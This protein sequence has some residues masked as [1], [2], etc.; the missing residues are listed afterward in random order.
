MA[1][2]TLETLPREFARKF[3]PKKLEIKGFADIEPLL[4]KLQQA[5]VSTKAN[6]EQ[7]LLD[8]SELFAA[9]D[10]FGS[11]VFIRNTL[12]T[13]NQDYKKAFLDFVEN[14]DPKL[15][16]VAIELNRKFK[17]SPA[18]D[19]L[20]AERYKVFVRGVLNRIE[21]YR[22]EN[23]T[24]EIEESKLEHEYDEIMGATSVKFEG[25]D[26]TPQAMGKF[27][28]ETD[29]SLRERAFRAIS[30]RRLLDADAVNVLYDKLV[31]LREKK[32]E[33]A[34]FPNYRDFAFRRR[35]RF[36]YTPADCEAYHKAVDDVVLPAVKRIHTRRAKHLKLKALRPWDT[37]VDPDGMPPLK[38]FEDVEKL[39]EGCSRVF[40]KV[41]TEL[42]DQFDMM[43]KLGLL[44]LANRKGKAPGGY[45]STLSEVRLPFIFMNAVGVDGDVQTLLH[46][47]GHAFHALAARKEPLL[48]YRGCP[49]EFCEVASMSMELLGNPHLDEFYPAADLKRARRDFYEGILEYLPWFATIDAYQQWVY[50]HKGHT[51][52]QR[53]KAW[54][55][56][57]RRF[58]PTIDWSGLEKFENLRWQ[59]Q[60][61]LF[62]AP[63]YYIEYAIAQLGA[64]QVWLNSRKDRKKALSQYK[65]ALSLGGSKPLPELFKAAGAKFDFSAKTV[66]PLVE[67]VE[68]EL[69][70]LE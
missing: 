21:L 19:Q 68:T 52:E 66:K 42:G 6:L 45:Q 22:D 51:I 5:D 64:L 28:L 31:R 12:D 47:G 26:R 53:M 40:H 3:V 17:A 48:E 62:G 15:K 67:A 38:P 8:G 25:E 11:R 59:Q 18:R 46:E 7:W 36:D 41:D 60:G 55:D 35:E 13:T 34:G 24:L 33:N 30:E 54:L 16:P 44:D 10:E 61:H 27:Q 56:V 50:T 39:K 4:S 29:R 9:I 2:D 57:F 70:M 49:I 69:A 43:R 32:A 20:D 37:A 23:V 63:F 58:N 14:F 65:F 1:T